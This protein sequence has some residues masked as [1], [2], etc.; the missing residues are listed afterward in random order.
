MRWFQNWFLLLMFAAAILVSIFSGP[1]VEMRRAWS[2][3]EHGLAEM[4]GDAPDNLTTESPAVK[5]PAERRAE[6]RTESVTARFT[7]TKRKRTTPFRSKKVAA[8]QGWKC[9]EC[10]QTLT[11]DYEID[12]A[13]PLH[14]GGSNDIS[15]LR[16]LHKRCHMLL[17]S[18]QQRARP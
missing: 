4:A 12:H 9:A 15:N 13:V 6:R 17:N 1:G 5:A 10:K 8:R 14:L 16:A 7:P 18:I 3:F 2:V 11:E